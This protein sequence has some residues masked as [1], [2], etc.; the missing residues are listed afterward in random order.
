M[1]GVKVAQVG[2]Q[3]LLPAGAAE[4]VVGAARAALAPE[5]AVHVGPVATVTA[6]SGALAA[7]RVVALHVVVE[8]QRQRAA[9]LTLHHLVRLRV[10]LSALQHTHTLT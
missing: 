4:Q 10:L 8:L 1:F 5:P 6:A 3:V 7:A 9:Q 2:G